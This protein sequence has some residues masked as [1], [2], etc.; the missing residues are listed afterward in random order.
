MP[1]LWNMPEF[2]GGLAFGSVA[3]FAGMLLGLA[4]SARA[5]RQPFPLGG[6]VIV[7]GALWSIADNRHV[8]TAALVGVIGIGAAA[9]LAHAPPVSRWHCTVLLVSAA[10]AIG[11]MLVADFDDTWRLD[12]AG[13][14]LFVVTALGV[15]ATVP[16]TELVGAVLGASLPLVLLGWPVCLASLGRVGGAAATALLLWA[17]AAGGGGRPAS[18]VAVV[19]CLGLLVGA[20]LGT[21]LLPRAAARLRRVP[22]TPLLLALV[23]SHAVVVLTAARV[24]GQRTDTFASVALGA[25]IAVAAV[26]VG[27]LFRPP[28]HAKAPARVN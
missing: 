13:L 14:T 15:Y 11:S 22:P 16:D 3:T 2:R 5:R 7:V 23:A 26:L 25:L 9:A 6:A 12:S 21:T 18:I 10:I 19:V 27:A 8:P 20:P 24:A 17:G 1:D 28:S 4:L